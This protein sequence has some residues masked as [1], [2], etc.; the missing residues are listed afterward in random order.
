MKEKVEIPFKLSNDGF[1][2]LDIIFLFYNNYD[3]IK[4]EKLTFVF[5]T[6]CNITVINTKFANRLNF[7]INKK[8]PKSKIR[9]GSKV[10][11]T[12]KYISPFAEVFEI[13]YK[14]ENFEIQFYVD[15]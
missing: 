1:I 7:K 6:G 11:T 3:E 13:S 14:I 9:T 4:S 12:Y 2:L 5:D 10:E 8:T 15:N